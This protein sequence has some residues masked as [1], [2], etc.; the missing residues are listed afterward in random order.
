MDAG[1]AG[2]RNCPVPSVARGNRC[3]AHDRKL[4]SAALTGDRTKL[5][6]PYRGHLDRLGK[7]ARGVKADFHSLWNS[8]LFLPGNSEL[9]VAP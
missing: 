9:C 6:A 2:Q 7:G 8:G 3:R 1:S 5:A 4:G